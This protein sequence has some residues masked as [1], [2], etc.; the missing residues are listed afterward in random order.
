MSDLSRTLAALDPKKREL[1]ALL[2]LREGI[3]LARTPTVPR[4][5]RARPERTGPARPAGA[6]GGD[7]PGA[8]ADRPAPPGRVPP[9]SLLRPGAALVPRSAGPRRHG[10]Q[11]AGRRAAARRD[12][13]GG[14]GADVRRDRPAARRAAHH[15]HDRLRDWRRAAGPGRR[16]AGPRAGAAQRPFG[17]PPSH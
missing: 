5:P 7:R 15:L 9:A 12:R 8:H 1:L 10:L 4:P 6:A 3:D 11:P 2:A 16:P 17:P 14:A 13:P